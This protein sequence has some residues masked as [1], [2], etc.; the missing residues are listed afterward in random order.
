MYR[1]G[2]TD[3]LLDTPVGE[4]PGRADCQR[5]LVRTP[6][7]V[8][9]L[10]EKAASKGRDG[11]ASRRHLREYARM[12]INPLIRSTLPLGSSHRVLVRI[13]AE[14]DIDMHTSMGR[15]HPRSREGHATSRTWKDSKFTGSGNDPEKDLMTCHTSESLELA[16]DGAGRNAGLG[17]GVHIMARLGLGLRV[18]LPFLNAASWGNVT[19]S[20]RNSSQN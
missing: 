1:V 20:A 16:E 2:G 13:A 10:G 4:Q 12:I 7:F 8:V 3:D 5:C 15:S 19:V 18:D 9:V 6:V 11:H 14:G 17:L